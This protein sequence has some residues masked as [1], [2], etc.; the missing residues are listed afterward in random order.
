MPIEAGRIFVFSFFIFLTSLFSAKSLYS[1]VKSDCVLRGQDTL[2]TTGVTLKKCLDLATLNTKTVVIP[3]NVTKIDKSGFSLCESSQQEGGLADI[4][5]IMDQSGS[6]AINYIWI[7]PD[8][9]DTV[10]LEGLGGCTIMRDADKNGFG[11][12]TLPN[13]AGTRQVPRLNPAKSLAGC[14]SFSG[15]PYT[16]RAVAFK[17]AIDFQAARAP[18][19][20]AG[21]IGFAANVLDQTRP[22]VL[23]STANVNR[24]KGNIV[25][26]SSGGTNYKAPLDSA[27]KWLLNP[28]ISPNPSK[29]II[30]LS[31]GRPTGTDSA[32]YVNVL[33][34]NYP[35]M[36]GIMPPIYGIFM[37]QPK[38]DT[39]KL[40]DMSKQTGGQFFLI[41]PSRPDSLQAVVARILNIILRQ[42]QPNGAS[43]TNNA[44]APPVTA[45][46]RAGDFQRQDDGSWLMNLDQQIPL[47]AQN[48]NAMTL[49]TELR[50]TNTGVLV[51]KSTLFTLSTTG[52]D[53]S[54][55]RN[56]PGTQF[57]I[58]CHDL[59]PPI[60]PVKVAY[61]K[62]TDGD[63]AGDKVFFVFTRPLTALPTSID[64]IYWNRVAPGFSNKAPPIL[65][66]LIGSGNTVVIADLTASQFPKGLTFIPAGEVPIAVLP[67]GGVLL[68]QRPAIN[69]S[70]GPIIDSVIARPFNNAKAIKGEDLNLDTLLIFVSEPML[71]E[72][73]WDG[74]LLFSKP[75]NGQCTD[76]EHAL[77]VKP[78]K[79]P[80]QD[81]GK[82]KFT[83]I[84]Q[85]GDGGPTPISGDCM[86]LNVNGV[87]TDLRQNDPPILGKIIRGRRPDREIELFRGYPPVVGFTA[88]NPGFILVNNDPRKGNE[89]DY[90]GKNALGQYVTVWVPPKGFVTAET[91]HSKIPIN[92][93]VLPIGNESQLAVAL[94]KGISTVQVVSTG[95]YIAD[96]SLFDNNGNF[97]KS[98]SQAFGYEGELNNRARITNKGLVSYLVWDLKDSKGQKAGQGV[99]IWKVKFRFENN[100]E[101]I[102]YTKTGVMR[103][104]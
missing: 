25:P 40:S 61:I 24:V 98:F 92:P 93:Q 5:Y 51:P 102:Q 46:A 87:Y 103:H 17:Q 37:G 39:L 15:D 82:Q 38:A 63:G 19:S 23:N 97:V 83:F 31:D 29:A 84:V 8:L 70:M 62:D 10:L 16:Q 74:L 58:V 7:S 28:V 4:V 42:Y 56:L 32:N 101:E 65:S 64:T 91:F 80:T 33:D 11:T 88:D 79:Q 49:A 85:A 96:I 76:F 14:N 3:A 12:V 78:Y 53:E 6:M 68:G 54:V 57:S 99:F 60:N 1:Q 75:V 27:K 2:L 48:S 55:N 89:L 71:S 18:S 52:P 73:T 34:A 13:D 94:P 9:R 66:F 100:K 81:P 50:E 36:P 86:F 22:L 69:D 45:T 77:A 44:L 43:L 67:A 47:F 104:L 35:Q 20:M 41:P 95:K 26:K 30:F 72:N 21:F 90:S 59:P